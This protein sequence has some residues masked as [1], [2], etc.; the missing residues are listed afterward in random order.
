MHGL[1]VQELCESRGGRP[2]LSV[3]TSL[4][5]SVD[6]NQYWTMLRHW[7]QFVRIC[8][9]ISEDRK[10]YFIIIMHGRAC[11]QYTCRSYNISISNAM[12]FDKKSFY[13]P[14]WN[15]NKNADGFQISHFDRSFSTD[16]V[17][18]ERFKKTSEWM[19][20]GESY[21]TERTRKITVGSNKDSFETN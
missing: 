7:S 5:A 11:K 4:M 1:R 10:L 9:P 21:R 14:A 8:Q 6:V 2:G 20:A 12:R 15:R 13:M 19:D 17:A 16:I 18:V 3:L